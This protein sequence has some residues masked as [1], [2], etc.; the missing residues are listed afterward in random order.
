[1]TRAEK[2]E[3]QAR[4]AVG[5]FAMQAAKNAVKKHIRAQGLR[6]LDFTAKEIALRAEALLKE[7]P[8]MIAQARERAAALGYVS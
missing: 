4:I 5:V 8:E 2:E 6:V 1:M 3:M 7:H